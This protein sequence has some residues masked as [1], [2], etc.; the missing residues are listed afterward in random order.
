MFTIIVAVV[1]FY[2]NVL[3]VESSE[4]RYFAEEIAVFCTGDSFNGHSRG[5]IS[6]TATVILL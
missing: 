1:L 2:G 3:V 6:V 5:F 4:P